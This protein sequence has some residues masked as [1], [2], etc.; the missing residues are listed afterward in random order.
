M[1]KQKMENLFAVSIKVDKTFWLFDFND[2][3]NT[4]Y[5]GTVPVST[6]GTNKRNAN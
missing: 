3:D 2:S 6:T 1:P 4:S 5:L